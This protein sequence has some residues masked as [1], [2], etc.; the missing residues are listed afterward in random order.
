MEFFPLKPE[1]F[2]IEISDSSIK[3]AKLKKRGRKVFL[4]SFSKIDL[5]KGVVEKGIIRDEEKL[6]LFIKKALNSCI[7]EKIKTKY[8]VASLPE[9]KTFLT[10]ISLPLMAKEEIESA[11]LFEVE[12][13]LPL[14]VEKLDFDWELISVPENLSSGIEILVCACEKEITNSYLRIFKKLSLEPVAFE[15]ESL[16][17]SRCFKK[18]KDKN[19]ALLNLGQTKTILNIYFKNSIRNSFVLP[20]GGELLTE[21]IAKNFKINF[22]EA[23]K[24]KIKHGLAIKLEKENETFKP[25]RG[26]IFEALIGALVDLADQVKRAIDFVETQKMIKSEKIEKIFICGGGA[27]LKGLKEFLSFKLNLPV[28][29]IDPLSALEIEAQ[30]LPKE[31]ILS[32]AT[33]LALAKRNYED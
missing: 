18:E 2:G 12:N 6:A 25:K 8:L 32:F 33:V 19:F 27:N 23:E 3:I 14:S 28:E 22:E 7:G 17:L 10:T 4:S 11:L 16:A 1:T 5:E 26:E 9:E 20:I 24:L 31:N 13:Y 15:S 30:I 21:L 29:K